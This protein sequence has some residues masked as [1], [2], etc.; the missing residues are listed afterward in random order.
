[1]GIPNRRL[2]WLELPKFLK[3]M[4]VNI[5]CIQEEKDFVEIS[6]SM[7]GQNGCDCHV[8]N[9]PVVGKWEVWRNKRV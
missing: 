9:V 5:E 6:N 2:P 4:S 7:K 8:M 3:Q 1:M